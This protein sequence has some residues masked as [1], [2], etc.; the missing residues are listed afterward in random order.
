VARGTLSARP[1]PRDV[2]N[3]Y[4]SAPA[5]PIVD[6]EAGAFIRRALNEASNPLLVILKPPLELLDL[7]AEELATGGAAS[8]STM[9][10]KATCA[11]YGSFNF[12]R[13]LEVFPEDGEAQLQ[14]L[15]RSFRVS[16]VAERGPSV[17]PAGILDGSNTDFGVFD[18]NFTELMVAWN[19]IAA[20]NLSRSVTEDAAALVAASAESDYTA[21]SKLAVRISRRAG[22]CRSI[23]DAR[24]VQIAAADP[25][26]AALLLDPAVFEPYL[27]VMDFVVNEHDALVWSEP[28]GTAAGP[29]GTTADGTIYCLTG[30]KGEEQAAVL[31]LVCSAV[32]AFCSL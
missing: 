7:M 8:G 27:K 13:V 2:L 16:V 30:R 6:E 19:D 24:G 25:I 3:C 20:R 26:V 9:L 31:A 10:R 4:D 22:V 28:D 29:G 5:A 11:V 15:L 32:D 17:G 1:Y 23:G 21:M 18:E 12:R 14:R